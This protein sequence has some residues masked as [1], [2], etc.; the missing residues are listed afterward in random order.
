[1]GWWRGYSEKVAQPGYEKID[2]IS[3]DLRN[4]VVFFSIFILLGL[5]FVGIRVGWLD[6]VATP[7]LWAFACLASGGAI[8]FLFGIPKILQNDIVANVTPDASASSTMT[9][10]AQGFPYRQRVN[11]NLEEI[12]D[13]LT[14]IIVGLGLVNL[15]EIPYQL[16]EIARLLANE[17]TPKG[18][19][20][21]ALA[22]IIYFSIM[23]LLFSY[24]FTRL[25]LQRAFARADLSVMTA[26]DVIRQEVDRAAK[27]AL[28]ANPQAGKELTEEQVEAAE[29]IGQLALQSN[30]SVVRQQVSVLA[31]EYEQVRVSMSAGDIR[32]RKMEVI[33]TKMRTLAIAAY[34]LL[35][36]LINSPSAG[37]RLAATAVLQVKPDISYVDWLATRL[38]NEKP[39]SGYH[40]AVA[41][42]YAVR[43]LGTLYPQQ[44]RQAIGEAKA[45][46]GQTN[47]DSDRYNI[48][49]QAEKEL[50]PING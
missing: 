22:L 41:L 24:L 32:T 12:S 46:L 26:G 33:V 4:T 14:K 36:E 18:Q 48:L 37:I 20:A 47:I 15:A 45:A 27:H 34:P 8:G 28:S 35:P 1:M 23:G 21:F 44:L 19:Q 49:D 38:A 6:T 10:P 11:T 29:Q 40:A 7:I 3:V 2:E 31:R 39:F 43:T 25:F 9:S 16:N 17:L 5:L 50:S 42:L 13:W 30:I